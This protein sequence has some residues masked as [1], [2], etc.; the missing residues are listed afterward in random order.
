MKL[1]VLREIFLEKVLITDLVPIIGIGLLRF[2]LLVSGLINY[3]FQ[4]V[5]PF[6]LNYLSCWHQLVLRYSYHLFNV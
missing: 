3:I 6:Q 2:L 5:G 1:S 4:V